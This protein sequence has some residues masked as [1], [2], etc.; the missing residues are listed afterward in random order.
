MTIESENIDA[1]SPLNLYRSALTLRRKYLLG[2]EA[3][4]EK[5]HSFRDVAGI[6]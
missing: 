2:S 6:K 5:T 3:K 4:L 1:A